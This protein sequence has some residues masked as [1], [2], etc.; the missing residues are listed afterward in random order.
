MG[1]IASWASCAL[2]FVLNTSTT[3]RASCGL[4]TY[5]NNATLSITKNTKD[6]SFETK[7]YELLTNDGLLVEVEGSELYGS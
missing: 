2:D 1:R 5:N 6:P 3:N 7:L 4:I